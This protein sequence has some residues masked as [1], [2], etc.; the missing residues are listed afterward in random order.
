M[1]PSGI[2]FGDVMGH[3]SGILARVTVSAAVTLPSVGLHAADWTIA[4]TV[5]TPS[6]IVA[7][8]AIAISALCLSRHR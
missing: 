7:D 1:L 2:H 5:L 4:G 3:L 6:G 8:G